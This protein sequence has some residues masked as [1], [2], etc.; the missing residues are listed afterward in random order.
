MVQDCL[1]LR[2]SFLTNQPPLMSNLY[3]LMSDNND[4][5]GN[6]QYIWDAYST[7]LYFFE[8]KFDRN[9]H[10]ASV[11]QSQP[12]QNSNITQQ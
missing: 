2:E 4:I 11:Y 7:R 9:D 8:Q 5:S 1:I 12:K 6:P 3:L 10:S